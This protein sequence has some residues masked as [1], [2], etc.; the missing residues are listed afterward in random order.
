LANAIDLARFDGIEPL[1]RRLL[2]DITQPLVGAMLA[3]LRPEKNH[4][5]LIR[6]MA[7]SKLAKQQIHVLLVGNDLNDDYSRRCHS[8]VAELGLQGNISF[9][10]SRSDVASILG[11]VD[12]GLLCSVSE[13]GPVALLEYGAS[14]LP[15]VATSTGQ[16]AAALQQA[17]VGIFAPPGSPVDYAAALDTLISQS[18]VERRKA[19]LRAREV[20]SELFDL[21]Q[22]VRLLQ[23]I[24][25]DLSKR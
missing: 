3:N 14:Q 1:P 8:L 20:V 24:Y 9:L 18:A 16:I 23:S 6:A 7:Q 2:A 19:G 15:F 21:G 25:Q 11:A 12:F 17:G 22:Q 4:E 10:G 5:T 13:S